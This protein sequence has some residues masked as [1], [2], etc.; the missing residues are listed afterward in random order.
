VQGKV[1]FSHC[2]PMILEMI[3]DTAK[4][5]SIELAGWKVVIGGAALPGALA[6]RALEE[7]VDVFTGYGMSESG[8]ILTLAHLKPEMEASDVDHQVKYRTKAGR[9]QHG[10]RQCP[11]DRSIRLSI[12]LAAGQCPSLPSSPDLSQFVLV[13]RAGIT[14]VAER[15]CSN[16]WE[17][18]TGAT[19]LVR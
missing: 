14:S 8:P 12:A 4:K 19:Q 5:R 7:G 6:W 3:L 11:A 13:R 1:T 9:Q 17:I 16:V 18:P 10:R 15:D 2:V